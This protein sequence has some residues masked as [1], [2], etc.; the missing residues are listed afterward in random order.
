M[1]SNQLLFVQMDSELTAVKKIRKKKKKRVVSGDNETHI[2]T[3]GVYDLSLTT[4]FYGVG[5]FQV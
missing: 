2:S 3:I 5:V 1:M 4:P